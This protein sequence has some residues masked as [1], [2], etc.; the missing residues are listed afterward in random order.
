MSAVNIIYLD[1][2][3][4][5]SVELTEKSGVIRYFERGERKTASLN[6]CMQPAEKTYEEILPRVKVLWNAFHKDIEPPCEPSFLCD[7]NNRERKS[8]CPVRN[9]CPYWNKEL[10]ENKTEEKEQQMVLY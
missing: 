2:S 5:A 1:S 9:L 4:W 3:G 10:R 6:A 8:Y 7:L